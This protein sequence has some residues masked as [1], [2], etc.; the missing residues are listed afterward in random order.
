V[1]EGLLVGAGE[2]S[3]LLLTEVQLEGKRRV[4]AADFLKGQRVAPGTVLGS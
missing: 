1:P 2:G 4:S 3:S